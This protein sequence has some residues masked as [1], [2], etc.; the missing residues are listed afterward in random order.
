MQLQKAEIELLTVSGVLC[1][2]CRSVIDGCDHRAGSR[3]CEECQPSDAY[4]TPDELS[5]IE[6]AGSVK[7]GGFSDTIKP[8]RETE[9][10]RVADW[11]LREQQR[12]HIRY[13]KEMALWADVYALARASSH[14][15][16]AASFA[17]DMAVQQFRKRYPCTETQSAQSSEAGAKAGGPCQSHATT[18]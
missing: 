6:T 17:S 1:E 2:T 10:D 5:S 18:K 8:K 15:H 3:T 12:D 11:F 16:D 9:N 7:T 4:E 13:E 14:D